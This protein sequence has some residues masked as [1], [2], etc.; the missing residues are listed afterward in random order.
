MALA[1]WAKV[2]S[3]GALYASVF[4]QAQAREVTMVNWY[5]LRWIWL[6]EG[7][8]HA[9]LPAGDQ[10]SGPDLGLASAVMV[11]DIVLLVTL[12]VWSGHVGSDSS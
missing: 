3:I 7:A 12:L 4:P 2:C 9:L 5:L 6:C 1:R 10:L 11:T 8:D